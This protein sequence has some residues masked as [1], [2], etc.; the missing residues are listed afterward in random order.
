MARLETCMNS[1]GFYNVILAQDG[2]PSAEKYRKDV[3]AV[4]NPRG[5]TLKIRDAVQRPREFISRGIRKHLVSAKL[6]Q[7]A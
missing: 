4:R 2:I 1:A 5:T 3:R 6:S 7:T